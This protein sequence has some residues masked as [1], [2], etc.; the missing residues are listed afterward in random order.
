LL[1]LT[2]CD[3][4]GNLVADVGTNCDT[5]VWMC[6]IQHT[7]CHM[8]AE[9]YACAA[10]EDE[11]IVA[12]NK[13]AVGKL[14]LTDQNIQGTT[15]A[16]QVGLHRVPLQSFEPPKY[17]PQGCGDPPGTG[18][19]GGAPACGAPGAACLDDSGCCSPLHCSLNSCD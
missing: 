8:T 1:S 9:Y 16:I 10:N 2:A 19:A 7:A 14:K 4:Y 3:W 5:T 6:T 11:A 15:C 17:E 18:G 12:A 13:L